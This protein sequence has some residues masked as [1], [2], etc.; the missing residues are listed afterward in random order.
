MITRYFLFD[1]LYEITH[2]YSG[3][4]EKIVA[5]LKINAK[6]DEIILSKGDSLVYASYANTITYREDINK[7]PDWIIPRYAYCLWENTSNC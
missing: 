5:Y 6:P 1:Y 3:P 2:S 7:S 4:N